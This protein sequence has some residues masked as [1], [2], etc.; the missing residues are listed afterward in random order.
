V[1]IAVT[2]EC[3]RPFSFEDKFAGQT[4]TCPD[5]SREIVVPAAPPRTP[6]ADPVFERD[7]FLIRQKI[8]LDEKYAVTDEAGTPL[9]FV[10]RPRHLLRNLGALFVGIIAG[11]AFA[12][13]CFMLVG[14]AKGTLANIMAVVGFTG[15]FTVTLTVGLALSTKRHTSFYRDESG[16]KPLL[17]ILQDKKFQPIVATYTVRDAQGKVLAHLRKN[18]LYNFVRKRWY[19]DAPGG[20]EICMAIED[21]ALL[22][23]LR[24]FIGPLFGLLRTNFRILAAESDETIGM[25]NRKMTIL[26]RYV[27]DLTADPDRTLDR[28][29]ALAVGVMLD[30][31]ERR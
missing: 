19:V 8:R 16:G 29:V 21:S 23:F 4:I 26:D 3:G 12:A 22:A 31:G 28:R 24:R 1:S 7:T 14:N 30:T 15:F 11:M 27:L 10:V 17:T 13:A 20:R 5:C 6:Q 25:F 18:Y 2:C 9:L